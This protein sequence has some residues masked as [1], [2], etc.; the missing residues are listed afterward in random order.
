MKAIFEP[1]TL[2]LEFVVKIKRIRTRWEKKWIQVRVWGAMEFDIIRF[3][4]VKF[5]GNKTF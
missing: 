1:K 5:D 4:L 2:I 3:S